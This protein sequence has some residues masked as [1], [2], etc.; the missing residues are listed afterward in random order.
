ML[1]T[2]E[3]FGLGLVDLIKF[4][5]V[6]ILLDDSPAPEAFDVA[7]VLAEEEAVLVLGAEAGLPAVED[8]VGLAP[9]F[10]ADEAVLV[11]VSEA[12]LPP[13]VD[14]VALAVL[15]AKNGDPAVLVLVADVGLPLVA[16]VLDVTVLLVKDEAT[17]VLGAE[18]GRPEGPLEPV[19]SAELVRRK[20]PPVWPWSE[21]ADEDF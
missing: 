17:L 20:E 13:V 8:F 15:L 14:V 10:G 4:L 5:S 3:D 2:G 11:F 6:L 1:L 18:V 19:E 7:A 12:R 9:F 16:D 21:V